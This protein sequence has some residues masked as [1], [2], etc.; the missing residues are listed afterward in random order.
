VFIRRNSIAVTGRLYA[1]NTVTWIENFD[2]TRVLVVCAYPGKP[3]DTV[4]FTYVD[5]LDSD[6]EKPIRMSVDQNGYVAVTAPAMTI[7]VVTQLFADIQPT[8]VRQNGSVA[9]ATWDSSAGI[10][11]VEVPAGQSIDLHVE[12]SIARTQRPKLRRTDDA[13]RV[14]RAGAMLEV[15]FSPLEST[16]E[17]ASVAIY[18]LRGSVIYSRRLDRLANQGVRRCFIPL[19][20]LPS[21]T[22]VLRVEHKGK[23]LYAKQLIIK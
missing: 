22:A 2:S 15:A 10:V 6:E 18:S 17:E 11:A 16:G 13:I 20:S 9:T 3:G 19:D 7:P 4:S 12:G 21:G 8:A 14:T 23:I 1:G 5:Y